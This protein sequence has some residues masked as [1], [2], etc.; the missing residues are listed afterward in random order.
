MTDTTG[1]VP[2][3]VVASMPQETV[4]EKLSASARVTVENDWKILS[5]EFLVGIIELFD[6]DQ[7]WR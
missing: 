2:N 1:M 7:I 6:I 4:R 3:P 5:T